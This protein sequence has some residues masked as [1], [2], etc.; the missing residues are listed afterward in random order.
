MTDSDLAL[1]Q[2]MQLTMDGWPDH[3]S[4]VPIH[5][6]PYW[7]FWDQVSFSNGILFKGEKIMIPKAM[8]PEMLKL[9]WFIVPIWAL[10]SAKDKI[11]ILYWLR[12]LSQIQYAV[13][14]CATCNI[15]QRKKQKEPLIPQSIP[16]R[17]WSKVGV[18]IFE[19]QQKQY[20][21][22]MDY[23][24]GFVELDLFTHTTA[25]QVINHCKS[26][27]SCHEMPD[28]LISDNDSQFSCHEFQWLI[29]HCRI[30]HHTSSPYHL[31][32][33]GMAEK[34]VQ[35]I[36]RL[37]KKAA[38]DGN[39]PYLALLEYHN[40]PWSDALGILAQWLMG[41]WT[42]IL[43]PTTSN[44]LKPETIS[45]IT[46]QEELWK[47]QRQQN[48]FTTAIQNHWKTSMLVN[49]YWWH[50]RT[51]DGSQPKWPV[52]VKHLLAHI[53]LWPHKVNIITETERT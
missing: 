44:L 13:S 31:Q 34:A 49:Q 17:P 46:V 24:L 52:S 28:V 10:R 11:D 29:K 40:T 23:Y 5:C 14:T 27:F 48:C 51:A 3:K 39:D 12:T 53:T 35:S 9:I 30:D 50:Q 26:Q 7:S 43:I 15:Y 6:L 45:P 41:K 21:V 25:K 47:H 16:D 37:M 2:L 42:K 19:L 32:F 36:K 22:I 4:R 38:H 8:Q 33:N 20:L 18:D 1:Q